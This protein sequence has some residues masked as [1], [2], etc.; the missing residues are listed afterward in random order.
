[1]GDTVALFPLEVSVSTASSGWNGPLDAL[2]LSR[3][4]LSYRILL[5]NCEIP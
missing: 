5:C 2:V 3:G 4:N 1:M